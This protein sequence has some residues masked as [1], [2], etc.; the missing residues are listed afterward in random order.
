LAVW[1]EFPNKSSGKNGKGGAAGWRLSAVF[2]LAG[3]RIGTSLFEMFGQ[4]P[5]AESAQAIATIALVKTMFGFPK[6]NREM[7]GRDWQF[8]FMGLVG[9]TYRCHGAVKEALQY[10]IA[11]R[12]KN[13][14]GH[15]ANGD[16]KSGGPQA[17]YAE[18]SWAIDC[19]LRRKDFANVF[20]APGCEQ[21]GLHAG[22]LAKA[23][24][25]LDKPGKPAVAP[26]LF[27][28]TMLKSLAAVSMKGIVPCA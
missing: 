16:A 6:G 23:K 24:P 5:A 11:I 12:G 15:E 17:E 27:P 28:L 9:C 8:A 7:N 25:L 1:T 22:R 14:T 19:N 20:V 18:L 26:E 21:T 4:R 13:R 2:G 3:G 10:V